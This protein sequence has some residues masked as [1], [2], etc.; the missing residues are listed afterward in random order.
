MTKPCYAVMDL[1]TTGNQL[2][3]D[4]IIQIGI[5]FVRENKIIG[6]YH[7][8]IKTDLEIPP[9]I[10]ALTSIEEAMLNQA[11]YFHEIAEDIYKQIDGCIFVAHNVAFDLNF[12]KKSFK[13]CDI[14]Y[15]PKKVMDTLELFKVAFPTDKSYQLSELAEAHG[16]VLNNAHRADEDAATTAQL[17]ILAFEKFEMLPLDTLKQL[18]YLSKNLKYDLHDILFEMVRNH[19]DKPLED[20]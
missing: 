5:T 9:F 18:Y 2:D 4:E 10:Q 8:M 19:K 17:M 11:P 12:I 14:N 15:R 16:I 6:T 7:S 13:N 3:Y 20:V 1:E